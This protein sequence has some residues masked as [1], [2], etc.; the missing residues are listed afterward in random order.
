MILLA[1][2][3]A[4]LYGVLLCYQVRNTPSQFNESKWIAY[5]LYNTAFSGV[6]VAGI[7]YGLPEDA[8]TQAVLISIG[9]LWCTSTTLAVLFIPKLFN[10]L[11]GTLTFTI[12]CSIMMMMMI[13]GEGIPNHT[14]VAESQVHCPFTIY[15]Y[16]DILS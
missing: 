14:Y 16:I 2:G 7:V 15:G 13:G 1:D 8:T 5:A 4:L 11:L 10:I 3:F 12:T 9:L 6:I